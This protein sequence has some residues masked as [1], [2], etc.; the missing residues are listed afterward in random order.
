MTYMGTDEQ[1]KMTF[2]LIS[3]NPQITDLGITSLKDTGDYEYTIEAVDQ[4]ALE[5]INDGYKHI[6]F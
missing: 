2:E 5:D 6:Y 4:E 1:K 3:T